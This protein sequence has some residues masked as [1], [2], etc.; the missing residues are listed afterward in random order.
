GALL[1]HTVVDGDGAGAAAEASPHAAHQGTHF[2]GVGA[3]VHQ[4]RSHAAV[5]LQLQDVRVA[6]AGV[7]VAFAGVGDVE[8]ILAGSLHGRG[9]DAAVV[10]VDASGLVAAVAVVRG[11]DQLRAAG[12]RVADGHFA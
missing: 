3:A 6:H 2:H 1:A 10:G 11:L 12:D 7:V 5:P 4:G 8:L 9:V